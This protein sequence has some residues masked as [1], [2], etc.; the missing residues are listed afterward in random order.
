MVYIIASTLSNIFFLFFLHFA[1]GICDSLMHVINLRM[2][3]EN[4]VDFLVSSIL[5]VCGMVCVLN[6]EMFRVAAKAVILGSKPAMKIMKKIKQKGTPLKLLSSRTAL[7]DF[8]PATEVSKYKGQPIQ[9]VS[10]IRG[11]V[12]KV[13][14]KLRNKFL[15]SLCVLQC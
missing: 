9:T 2:Q 5:I 8:T 3:F 12:K 10:G 14:A 13:C 11:K 4:I 6:Q 7:I 1:V 15:S